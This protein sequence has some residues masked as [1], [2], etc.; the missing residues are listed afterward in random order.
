MKILT[1]SVD[2]ELSELRRGILEAAGHEVV[3]VTSERE[4][5][6]AVQD[7]ETY[8][9]VLLCH[10]LPGA[11]AR[12]IVRLLRQ[13]HPDTRTVYIGHVYGEWPELEADRY[14][15]GADGPEALLR[16][17]KEVQVER[18]AA[19]PVRAGEAQE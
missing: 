15:V 17:L 4:V 16:V 2:Q 19:L 9:I 12:T 1:L 8:E 11:T 13:A 5:L 18:T 3:A 14:I 10:K 7:D 6:Q